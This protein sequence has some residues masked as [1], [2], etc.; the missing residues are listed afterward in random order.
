MN[1][2]VISSLK[3]TF[4][5]ETSLLPQSR[6]NGSFVTYVKLAN[7][8]FI[9]E[10]PKKWVMTLNVFLWAESRSFDFF[11][12]AQRPHACCKYTFDI[13]R[14]NR[15]HTSN[16]VSKVH[17]YKT[18][19]IIS[20]LLYCILM[21]L[22]LTFIC[23]CIKSQTD[24]QGFYKVVPLIIDGQNL[25]YVYIKSKYVFSAAWVLLW[26]KTEIL[27][28]SWTAFLLCIKG[29]RFTL[30][31]NWKATCVFLFVLKCFW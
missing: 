7:V 24:T 28:D 30:E 5:T 13:W 22:F 26:L 25:Y 17:K 11:I 20:K 8:V 10:C 31:Q 3:F 21:K 18:V 6:F 23:A 16:H 15:I 19:Q 29:S 12:S 1:A 14:M 2:S 9:T 27:S 4:H